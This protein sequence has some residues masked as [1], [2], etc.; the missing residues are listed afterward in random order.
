MAENSNLKTPAGA[1]ASGQVDLGT[2]LTILEDLEG[3]MSE[4]YSWL[5]GLFEEDT[6]SA[7]FF[8]SMACDE[9]GHRDLVR[10]E[11]QLVLKNRGAFAA[12]DIDASVL[13]GLVAVVVDFRESSPNPSL[14]QA[15]DFLQDIENDAAENHYRTAI[16]ESN[17]KMAKLINSLAKQDEHHAAK[18]AAF[19]R[20]RGFGRANGG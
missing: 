8:I 7:K 5:A 14:E 6:A 17:P 10:F 19:A 11:R 13:R 4:L 16:A 2:L 18:L 9:A 15:L 20:L 1:P 12:V 3:Q